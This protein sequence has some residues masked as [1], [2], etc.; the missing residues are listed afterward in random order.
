MKIISFLCE[1]Y[2]NIFQE[3]NYQY[4][5]I[6]SDDGFAPIWTNVG[7]VYWRKYAS[8]GLNKLKQEIKN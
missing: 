1:F 4:T 7:L 3:S 8:L 5:S 2:L 6:G